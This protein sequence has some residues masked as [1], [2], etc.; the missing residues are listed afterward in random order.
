MIAVSQKKY[1]FL[2]DKT[3]LELHCLKDF[4]EVNRLEYLPFHYLLSSVGNAGYLKYV[5]I[6]T[7]SLISEHR[8]RLGQCKV[9]TTNKQNG[10]VGLG[11]AQWYCFFMVSELSTAIG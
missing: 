11:H 8:T 3:G 9:M 5:D 1:T 4:I 10:I 2:Y 6:S 7:G